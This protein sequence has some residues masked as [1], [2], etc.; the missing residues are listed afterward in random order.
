MKKVSLTTLVLIGWFALLMYRSDQ[1]VIASAAQSPPCNS[2]TSEFLF[3]QFRDFE[4]NVICEQDNIENYSFNSGAGFYTPVPVNVQCG[5]NP[6]CDLIPTLRRQVCDCDHDNDSYPAPGCGGQDCDDFNSS[7]NPG[8]EEICANSIDDDCDGDIDF[9]SEAQAC[10]LWGFWDEFLCYCWTATPIIVDPTGNGFLLT[11]LRDG[12]NFDLDGNGSKE[13]VSWTNGTSDD[14]FLA[15]DRNGDGTIDSGAELFGSSTQQSYSQFPNGFLALSEFDKAENGGNAD[16]RIDSNDSVFSSLRL[17]RDSNHNG[18]SEASELR[19]LIS[20][21]LFA[22][23]LD[24]SESRR[25]D[26][27]GNQFRYR[28]RLYD[29]RGTQFGRW[30]WDVILL[31][32]Q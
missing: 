15:L 1:L 2:T 6:E 8:A 10:N 12:V 4:N 7:V 9:Y 14:A 26:Q 11:G 32:Q 5:G 31:R 27:F 16:G 28:A 13:R 17:W 18:I 24:Y 20:L 19:S 23:S 3:C 22:I 29:S 25:I 30:A 21:N